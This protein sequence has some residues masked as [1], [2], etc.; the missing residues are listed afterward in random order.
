MKRRN[1]RKNQY[2]AIQRFVKMLDLPEFAMGRD[3]CIEIWGGNTVLVE[4]ARGV[5]TYEPEI[6]RIQM[7]KYRLVLRGNG[8]DLAH[9]GNGCLRVTGV[10]KQLEWE[11]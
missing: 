11:E 9:F 2:N 3:E 1:K 5:H 4:G 8:F 10:L 7:K 6:V